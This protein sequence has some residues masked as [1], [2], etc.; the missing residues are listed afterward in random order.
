MSRVK[1]HFAGWHRETFQIEYLQA[2]QV[3]K[4][5]QVNNSRH[6]FFS[7]MPIN[8]YKAELMAAMH[9]I[10][11]VHACGNNDDRAAQS[12]GTKNKVQNS[13]NTKTRRREQNLERLA[14]Q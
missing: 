6:S 12:F 11:V 5:L 13:E 7:L 1:G 2:N 9:A 8:Q 14:V 10:L 3:K 4:T